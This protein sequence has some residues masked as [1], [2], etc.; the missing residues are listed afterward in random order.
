[1]IRCDICHFRNPEGFAYCGR[2]GNALSYE[3]VD[4]TLIDAAPLEGERKQ[5]TILFADI[6]GF[7]A[8][9][10]A[11]QSQADV[12][13]V[14]QIV[15]HC[16]DMLTEAVYEFDGYIDK[17][18]GDAIMATFGAPRVH[19]DDPERALRAALAM[20]ERLD[21]FNRNPP[22]PLAE[23]LGIHI[24]INTGRV[25]AGLIGSRRKRSYTV[26]GDAVNVAAR[27]EDVSERGEFLV[28]QDTYNLTNRMFVFKEREPV[29]VKGKKEPLI[30]YELIG[31]RSQ[32][33]SQRGI[34]GLRAPMVGRTNEIET[35]RGSIRR[36]LKGQGSINVIIGEAGLGKSRLTSELQREV[37]DYSPDIHWFEGRGL[38]FQQHHSF[39]LFNE[40]L[41]QYLGVGSD[42][43]GE[44]VWLKW[45]QI[46]E[47]LFKDRVSMVIPYLATLM[48]L[49]LAEDVTQSMPL[50]DPNQLRQR[51]YAAVGDWV[52][53]VTRSNPMVL[54]FEDLHW[55]DT[56]SIN[57][58]EHLMSHSA[59]LPVQ[60][61]C[62]TRPDKTTDFW[63]VRNRALQTYNGGYTELNLVPLTD[64]QSRFLVDQLLSVE[65]LPDTLE[66]LIFSRSEGNPLFMEEVLRSLI[67]DETLVKT[68]DTWTTTRSIT[69]INI[70]E[71]LNG[72]LTARIDRLDEPV[73]RT[74]QIASVVGRVFARDT[75]EAVPDLPTA[76]DDNLATLM[77]AELVRERS[78]E[79]EGVFIFKHVLVQEAAYN[80]LLL[81]QRQTYHRQI[82]DHLA[83]LYWMRGEEHA[84]NAAHH[85]EQGYAWDRTMTYLIRA[86]EASQSAFD[87]SSAIQFYSRA[88]DISPKVDT[89]KNDTLIKIYKG[90]GDLV[91]RLGQI[92]AA[93][94][95]FEHIL[96]LAMENDDPILQ[97][98]ALSELGKL[99]DSYEDYHKPAR[100][101]ERALAL[102]RRVEDLPGIV[103]MLN[104][105]AD[106]HLN[107]GDRIRADVYLKEALS[108]ARTLNNTQHIANC[109]NGLTAI[110]LYQGQT[111]ESIA[112][113]EDLAQTWR[114]LGDYRGLMRSYVPLAYAYALSGNTIRSTEICH[115]ALEILDRFGDLNWMPPVHF[116]LA[117]NA[118]AQGLL[119]NA[120]QDIQH[121]TETA[122]NLGK[123]IWHAV[124]LAYQ[125]YLHLLLGQ[126]ETG[127]A[128]I[129]QA[130]R[131]AQQIAAPLWSNRINVIQGISYRYQRNFDAAEAL[132]SETYRQSQT[133][134]YAPEQVSTLAELLTLYVEAERWEQIP[135]LLTELT[136]LATTNELPLYQAC[137]AWVA[138]Q[139]ACQENKF[140]QA[141]ALIRQ[142]K[143]QAQTDTF[144][145]PWLIWRLKTLQAQVLL[146]QGN[147]IE[148]RRILDEAER[149]LRQIANTIIP[150]EDRL[151][152]MNLHQQGQFQ[153][154]R[155]SL[156]TNNGT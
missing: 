61:I 37:N 33:A 138:A 40:I 111:T 50:S 4:T 156:A 25:I 13:Q 1:M 14:L 137:A 34:A 41:R 67:E 131:I 11:A 117:R 81:Q 116:Q 142:A 112:K 145:N 5:V 78:G 77:A 136:T 2:C 151:M 22:F 130:A 126:V 56:N 76:L 44:V 7:T 96:L 147:A 71:T 86:A 98:R 45:Q 15:N 19:E 9:N 106:Y 113:L 62:V 47:Q 155:Q 153:T 55:A 30:I 46:G 12:E 24:G 53:A 27:L 100:Y 42:E 66:H 75:L 54:V 72:V 8:L 58:L 124:G 132:L 43:A 63:S 92:D 91:K 38:S 23:P 114:N 143:K 88:L 87:N 139:L 39:R 28:S 120:K 85:Y 84:S 70:P 60:L 49:K 125:G 148:A 69:E 57:L 83:Q 123:G 6:S 119:G 140:T 128:P 21:E 107:M 127:L 109:E 146:K 103:D 122:H 29:S 134:G 10:D 35:L 150:E 80:S 115:D 105:L 32:R 154:V 51:M 94:A 65:H 102:A 16:F 141:L 104:E 97:M 64:D 121:L 18:M 101:F 36:L 144:H 82:A 108:I 90:R 152:F 52:E 110:V 17:Y 73:K 149:V 59:Q 135:D 3:T 26:M 79:R 93:K 133:M 74:L 31:A 20:R 95:D 118:L 48:G 89:L 68:G 129:A 99:H